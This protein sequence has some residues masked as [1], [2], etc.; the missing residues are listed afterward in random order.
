MVFKFFGHMLR[1]RQVS[2]LILFEEIRITFEMV[3]PKA[4]FGAEISTSFDLCAVW[5]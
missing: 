5:R 2:A 3:H 4:E 1:R